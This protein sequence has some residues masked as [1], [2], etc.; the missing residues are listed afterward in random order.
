MKIHKRPR[1]RSVTRRRSFGSRHKCRNCNGPLDEDDLNVC[2]TCV[3]AKNERQ[4][5]KNIKTNNDAPQRHTSD[6]NANNP[7]KNCELCNQLGFKCFQ[8]KR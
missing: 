1:R 6:T 8:C 7:S 2:K 4:P 3:R 5:K